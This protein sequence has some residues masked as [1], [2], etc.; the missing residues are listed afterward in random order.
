MSELERLIDMLRPAS[1][2]ERAIGLLETEVFPALERLDREQLSAALA[3]AVF[4]IHCLENET[5]SLEDISQEILQHQLQAKFED[6]VRAREAVKHAG[7]KALSENATKGARARS[8]KYEPL[9][10]FAYDEAVAGKYHNRTRAAEEVAPK[11]IRY[12]QEKGLPELGESEAFDT[13]YR[14]LTE[15]GY[16]RSD[17]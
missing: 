8:A 7:A 13:V 17:L 11:V 5:S 12:A 14:W 1:E 3:E 6:R 4:A 15:K 16:T 9:R 2:R 10:N